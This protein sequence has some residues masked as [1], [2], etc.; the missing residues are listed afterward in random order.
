MRCSAAQVWS[1][2]QGPAQPSPAVLPGPSLSP[3]LFRACVKVS[4]VCL[5][6]V[7]QAVSQSVAVLLAQSSTPSLSRIHLRSP[8]SSRTSRTGLVPG[9]W[10]MHIVHLD[11]HTAPVRHFHLACTF[12]PNLPTPCLPAPCSLHLAPIPPP[13][14]PLRAGWLGVCV[15]VLL[16]V[17]VRVCLR[18]HGRRGVELISKF[19]IH[20]HP[21]PPIWSTMATVPC[22]CPSRAS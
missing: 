15:C 19:H 18:E 6:S 5:Q 17:R 13:S 9:K 11:C 12:L 16:N 1:G 7:R 2:R 3:S 20:I 8:S 21:Y 10:C 22:T 4:P 14:F